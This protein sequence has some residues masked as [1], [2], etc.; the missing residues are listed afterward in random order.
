MEE[1]NSINDLAI[2]TLLPS[3]EVLEPQIV[4]GWKV[5]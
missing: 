1:K 3:Q 4:G 5:S 2:E